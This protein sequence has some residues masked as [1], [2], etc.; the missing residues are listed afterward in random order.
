MKITIQK[1]L[2][3]NFSPVYNYKIVNMYL[4]FSFINDVIV[5]LSENTM[6]LE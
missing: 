5:S 2:A 6:T 3:S 1:I 4:K